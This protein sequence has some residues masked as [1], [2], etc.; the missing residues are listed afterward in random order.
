[1]KRIFIVDEHISS[2]QNGVGTYMQQ[3]LDCM[4][5]PDVELNLLSFNSDDNKDFTI[6]RKWG[7]YYYCFPVCVQRRFLMNGP[8]MMAVLKLYVVDSPDN[9][10]FVN[11]S[12]CEKFLA[13]LKEAFP[14]SKLVFTIHDQGWTA[15]LL[16]DGQL[17]CKVLQLKYL[18]KAHRDNYKF[19]REYCAKE[20]TM[21]DIVD[22]VVCLSE[23]T[24]RLL[25]NVY[26]V[27]AY[28]ISVIPNGWK[29]KKNLRENVS[30][31]DLRQRLNIGTNEKVLLFVGRP[32]KA[33]GIEI[34]LKAFEVVYKKHP[35][36]RLII[37]GQVL[38]LNN[39]AKLVPESI[40]RIVFTGLI[41]AESVDEWYR[42]A[43]IGVLPSYSEQCSFSGIEM[44]AAGLL[45]VATDGRG[46]KEMFHD[47]ENSL[48]AK[49][50]NGEVEMEFVKNLTKVLLQALD[51]PEKDRN[52]LCNQAQADAFFRYSLPRMRDGYQY[53]L[54]RLFEG[55]SSLT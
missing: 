2:K 20:R 39:Y 25:Q 10:F 51:L 36:V 8:I 52:K 12:P 23:E 4:K 16:G 42:I 30:K 35:E 18:P 11:H 49:I 19:V 7:V 34:L 46:L 41:S 22:A 26:N 9:V 3:F 38:S 54:K 15:P 1:M 21:Y 45:V 33:K 13:A 27:P 47:G 53:L 17:L 5:N 44:L 14:L 28:K 31:E 43:D 37:L 40:T 24:N 6:F 29:Q 48:V 55:N 50:G 32:V